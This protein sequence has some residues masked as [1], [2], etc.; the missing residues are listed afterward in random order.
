MYATLGLDLSFGK[1]T[2]VKVSKLNNP[3]AEAR[4]IIVVSL[5]NLKNLEVSSELLMRL[6]KLHGRR[7][8]A[9]NNKIMIMYFGKVLHFKI[10]SIKAVLSEPS[11]EEGFN[12]LNL[13]QQ[14][15]KATQDTQWIV[16]K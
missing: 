2:Y 11:F 7:V 9:E 14:F 13:E 1:D 10:K 8:L 4:Q 16:C 5:T 3:A 12:K 15:Y 6:R